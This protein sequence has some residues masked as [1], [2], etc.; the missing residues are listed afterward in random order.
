MR[1]NFS[2]AVKKLLA[3]RVNYKCSNPICSRPTSGPSIELNQ[4]V[5]IGEAAHITAAAQRGPRYNELMTYE[6]RTSAANGI[7]LC[8]VC[9]KLIDSDIDR[10]P[11]SVIE[12]W[13]K[14]AEESARSG[15]DGIAIAPLGRAHARV[16]VVASLSYHEARQQLISAGW[17]PLLNHFSHFE[18]V[19]TH[20]GNAH[21]FLGRGYY[22]L[23]NASPTGLSFCLFKLRDMYK[24]V[25][26]V[27]T[28]GEENPKENI[29]AVVCSWWLEPP[30]ESNKTE[31]RPSIGTVGA[32]ANFFDHIR[33]GTPQ[34]R[35]KEILGVPHLRIGE[36]WCYRF[37]DALIQMEFDTYQTVRY[38]AL[39]VTNETLPA[40][41]SVPWVDKCLG[42]LTLADVAEEEGELEYRSTLRTEEILWRARLGLPGAWQHYT[43]GALW[44][45]RPGRLP[46]PGFVWN[47]ET[48]NL[49]SDPSELIFN[50][51]AISA[52][53]EDIWFDWSLAF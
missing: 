38:A 13:K 44:P 42:S 33:P 35:I 14:Q 5:N 23:E 31:N 43:F 21:E 10:F 28:A 9:A 37:Q 8:S 36:T 26:H 15:L 41:F 47:Y 46:E 34:E 24:N 2:A 32:P 12:H 39:A 22:E 11:V 4:S 19:D 40:G 3:S 16:P 50:W 48:G 6:Q 30:S 25:L 17:Q 27:V 45:H 7:W 20:A 29:V 53:S 51:V 1:E 18:S 49:I 52:T